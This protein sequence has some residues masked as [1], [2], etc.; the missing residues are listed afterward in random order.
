MNSS[1]ILASARYWL[2]L[3]VLGCSPSLAQE[4]HAQPLAT[5]EVSLRFAEG[6]PAGEERQVSLA[7]RRIPAPAELQE[8]I[9]A[10]IE[11]DVSIPGESSIDLPEGTTWKLILRSEGLWAA[12]QLVKAG[13]GKVRSKVTGYP[14]GAVGAH[15]VLSA[16]R[17]APEQVVLRIHPTEND[18]KA[19]R[20]QIRCPVEEK[21]IQCG[22]P[23]GVYDVK[24][25]AA[26]HVPTYRWGQEIEAGKTLDL[27]RIRLRAG[28]SITGWIAAPDRG[29]DFST[30]ELR[31]EP[32]VAGTKPAIE[33][34]RRQVLTEKASPD[35][36]GFFQ[37]AG[38]AEGIY[39]L[40]AEHPEHAPTV[41]SGLE[42]V[43]GEELEL[44]PIDLLPA[45]Q[46][47]LEIAQPQDPF[48]KPWAVRLSMKGTEGGNLST[49][50]EGPASPEGQWSAGGLA[51][52][53]YSLRVTDHRGNSWHWQEL[54][55]FPHRNEHRITIDVRRFEGLLL[56]DG[57]PVTQASVALS[58]H[59][60]NARM[61]VNSDDQGRFYAFLPPERDWNI[62]IRQEIDSV[63]AFFS[64]VT[65]PERRPNDPWPKKTFEIPDTHLEGRVVDGNGLPVLD[66]PSLVSAG[67]EDYPQRLSLRVAG[68]AFEIRGLPPG[69]VNLE[70]RYDRSVTERHGATMA[71]V[72]AELV[73]GR[74]TG[75]V[76][77]VLEESV[78]IIGQVVATDGRGIPGVKV[79]GIAEGVGGQRFSSTVEQATSDLDGVFE[80]PLPPA[81]EY[82]HL[83]FFPPGY[84]VTQ[85][86]IRARDTEPLIVV[87]EPVGGTLVV[88]YR[89]EG[90]S[91]SPAEL[92]SRTQ[93]A[94]KSL[95]FG[96][97]LRYWQ[98]L[99]GIPDD[100]G[101]FIAPM[102]EPGPYLVC[103]GLQPSSYLVLGRLP[104][105][106]VAAEYCVSGDLPPHGEL[107]L[108]LPVREEG[109]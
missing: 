47:W 32:M 78:M 19:P 108:D 85:R 5:V 52:G 6:V 51:P 16:H 12:E 21:M 45:S 4:P 83:S 71:K 24:I 75:P 79:L 44:E 74:T 43:A 62:Q 92:K 18:P 1:G 82:G 40:T 73:E 10:E 36:H 59:D 77:L 60:G 9:E 34:H 68:G 17:A 101:R 96:L 38:V 29:F 30:V 63:L 46:L 103:M 49:V 94:A 33:R 87:V 69:L 91:Y 11:M 95:L 28:A 72:H 105:P 23:K 67:G 2:A 37:L 99:Y 102:L 54:P 106:E 65:L 39:V 56:L 27:G 58:E 100:P 55:I 26:G 3:L 31:L 89:Q 80:I 86:R 22:A 76:E 14:A 25:T 104:P 93:I 53:D 13:P 84:A 20:A 81:A 97:Q 35:D 50:E 66:P 15:L 7:L 107:H 64:E 48:R 109:L 90:T 98:E 61:T 41:L 8:G 57:Q 88:S 70:A 42:V